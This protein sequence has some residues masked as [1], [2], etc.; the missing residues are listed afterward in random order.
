VSVRGWFFQRSV[1]WPMR[2][3]RNLEA[4]CDLVS[5]SLLTRQHP[6]VQSPATNYTRPG[7]MYHR[8]RNARNAKLVP[9]QSL[10]RWSEPFFSLILE[11]EVW[12]LNR[13]SANATATSRR[14]AIDFDRN[15]R[16]TDISTCS[17]GA[18][19]LGVTVRLEHKTS[20]HVARRYFHCDN[21]A[22]GP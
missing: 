18:E 20:Q 17:S 22:A 15:V 16:K 2:T 19:M 7:R 5:L 11:S 14:L 10:T 1:T 8:C 12:N 21:I 13:H 9:R 4:A 6:Q 3:W